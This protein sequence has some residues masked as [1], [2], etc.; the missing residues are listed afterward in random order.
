MDPFSMKQRYIRHYL[1]ENKSHSTVG[2]RSRK[3]DWKGKRRS[4]APLQSALQ[5]VEENVSSLKPAFKMHG[6]IRAIQL[7]RVGP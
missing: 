4:R 5:R 7:G 1:V 3:P 2:F 6:L